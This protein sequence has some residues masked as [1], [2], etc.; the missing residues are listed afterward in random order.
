MASVS[1]YNEAVTLQS[2]A[3]GTVHVQACCKQVD[4]VMSR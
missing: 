4:I 3:Y 2:S 1:V